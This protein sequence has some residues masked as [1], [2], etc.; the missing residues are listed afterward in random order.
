M[1][2][3]A[4]LEKFGIK[5]DGN[6]DITKDPK[7]QNNTQEKAVKKTSIED[8]QEKDLVL[9]KSVQ[10]PICDHK[11][12]TLIVKSAKVKREGSDPDLRPHYHNIDTLKYEVCVCP[13]CGYAAMNKYFNHVS[14]TQMKW[15]KEAVCSK[16]TPLSDDV[17]EIYTADRAVDRYK[18]ALVSTLAKHGQMSEK[19][20][21]CLR[22]AWIRRDQI[23]ETPDHTPEQLKKRKELMEEYE[24]FYRQAYD[25]F[26]KAYS[27][28]TGPYAGLSGNTLEFILANMAIHFKDYGT[29]SKLI[30]G[31]LGNPNTPQRVKDKCLDLKEKI[32]AAAKK[33]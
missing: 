20:L 6:L 2:L 31:L 32:T 25:G 4:G 30:S 16:F 13:K 10:C 24:G 1:N 29:A 19:A 12:K 11:F 15:I 9:Q 28:E 17:P 23:K 14:S 8:L 5:S 3:L 18:L 27:T 22:I 33:N 7:T 26:N 21:I